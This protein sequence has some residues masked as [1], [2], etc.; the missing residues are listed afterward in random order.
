MAYLLGIPKL[1][2]TYIL[3]RITNWRSIQCF[4]WVLAK[5]NG[6]AM[7]E[8]GLRFRIYFLD[9]DVNMVMHIRC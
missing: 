4:D 7:Q 5:V 6:I 2:P 3:T 1:Q 8:Y 9:Q